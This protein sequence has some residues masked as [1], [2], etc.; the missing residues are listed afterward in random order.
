MT[1]AELKNL[2]LVVID[3]NLDQISDKDKPIIMRLR[4]QIEIQLAE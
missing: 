1:K 3:D 2:L 4:V